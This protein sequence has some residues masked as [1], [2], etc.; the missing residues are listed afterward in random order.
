MRPTH[1]LL[2]H[3]P[4]KRITYNEKAGV[5]PAFFLHLIYSDRLLLEFYFHHHL[6]TSK[7]RQ[8]ERR[9]VRSKF[10]IPD[11]NLVVLVKKAQQFLF[12]ALN[13]FL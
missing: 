10:Y 7:K 12:V 9:I 2:M 3:Q 11:N 1:R 13:I 6:V 8:G 4:I 5:I